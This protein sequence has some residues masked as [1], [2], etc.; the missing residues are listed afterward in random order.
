[1]PTAIGL[2]KFTPICGLRYT[3]GV[4][5]L[6]KSDRRETVVLLRRLL[7]AVHRGELSADGPVGAGLVRR[8]EGAATA[9]EL[10]D[11]P[12]EPPR[13]PVGERHKI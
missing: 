3:M 11:R 5:G 13:G 1:M 4:V 9:L 6:S 10:T 2:G 7:D 12:K 8:L